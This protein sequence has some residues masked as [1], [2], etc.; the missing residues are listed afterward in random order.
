MA[1]A[2]KPTNFEV[3]KSLFPQTPA[4]WDSR[5][6]LTSQT[7][8]NDA[9]VVIADDSFQPVR[10]QIFNA[11]INRI[12]LTLVRQRNFA[13]PLS[14]FKKG[15]MP[16]GD[17]MQEIAVD[18]TEAQQYATGNA[19]QFETADPK[20]KAAYHTVNR[21][22]FY[23]TTVYDTQLQYAFI[24]EYGLSTLISN[25]V[26]TLQSSNVI[27]EFIYTK[28]LL[29]SFLTND[30]YPIRDTQILTVNPIS[31]RPRTNE[32]IVYFLEDVK[33]LMRR[34]QFP[35]RNYNAAGQMTQVTPDNMVL[36]LNSDIIAI[37][38]VNNLAFA[39]RP[40]YMNLDIPIIAVDQISATDPSLIGAIVSASSLD[41]RT[42]KESFRVAENAQALYTNYFFH[43]HQIYTASAFE[44][45]AFIKEGA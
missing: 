5:I 21:Q 37:N 36:V 15:Y 18:V 28:K 1:T 14:M 26:G 17:T 6:N 13:N 31:A 4:N 16:F 42:T 12:G 11:L 41:I 32:N 10:N 24:D 33:K 38:E 30:E 2:N 9:K 8:W 44:T 39:F 25:I 35:T 20:V 19:N 3:V 23:K 22:Q 34:M 29:E 45:L 40:E 43:I 27:D 7:F